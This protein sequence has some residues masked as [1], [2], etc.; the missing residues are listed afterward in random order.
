MNWINLLHFYQ[1]PNQDGRLLR[2]IAK[3]SY[4]Y[5]ISTLKKNPDARCSV[6]I[7][8]SLTE[9]L[10]K[11]KLNSV[12]NG[13]KDLAKN[14]QIEIV[15]TAKYHPILPLIPK[16]E[17]V[18]QIELNDKITRA[19]FGS[20]YNPSG[21][22][23]PELAYSE[24]VAKIIKSRGYKWI[25]LDEVSHSGQLGCLNYGK[26]YIIKNNGLE[27][28]FRNRGVSKSYV[29]EKIL[30]FT[31]YMVK[32]DYVITATD[33]EMYGHHH[34]D[35]ANLYNKALQNPSVKTATM[36]QLLRM[37]SEEEYVTPVPASWESRPH[38]LQKNIPYALWDD[39]KNKIHSQLWKLA[40]FAIKAV[41]ENTESES[42]DWARKHLDV[43]LASCHWWWASERKPDAFTPI[44]W[45]PNI[46]ERGA[47]ELISSIRSLESTSPETKIHAEELFLR[48][49]KDVWKK[50]W[51]INKES[52]R[53][54]KPKRFN[55]ALLT[56]RKENVFEKYSLTPQHIL[57]TTGHYYVTGCV[58]KRG[59]EYILKIRLKDNALEKKLFLKEIAFWKML[60]RL[61]HYPLS[62]P[63][64][65][66]FD[67][68]RKPEYLLYQKID[69][70]GIGNLHYIY[71]IKSSFE[72]VKSIFNGL[73][74]LQKNTDKIRKGLPRINKKTFAENMKFFRSFQTTAL[75]YLPKESLADAEKIIKKN[76]KF[77]NR[78]PLV[79]SHG[80]L[81]PRNIIVSGKKTAL[82]DWSNICLNNEM[83][84]VAFLSLYFLLP[85]KTDSDVYSAFVG[86]NGNDEKKRLFLLNQ[87]II[88]PK[89]IQIQ[90]DSIKYADTI[91]KKIIYD[92]LDS[93]KALIKE[94]NNVLLV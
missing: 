27:V 61:K 40:N 50:H 81:N 82:I 29:P 5:I 85:P 35:Y 62:K 43:G 70:Q 89:F 3:E 80:D 84:D 72:S 15:G 51:N 58:N 78:Q 16:K 24:E 93:L 65:I 60:S 14:G 77:I 52:K 87:L 17:V 9:Q 36:T 83:F 8:G 69:G 45:D 44:T 75:Q 88:I 32:P 49:S 13:L 4:L 92:T 28:V 31:K 11:L 37:Y 25:L 79:I 2:Q 19:Y 57:S 54:K 12:I 66:Y 48:I 63:K 21:F 91:Q 55:A 18:R 38:E 1:P 67:V 71:N 23:A 74:Y 10:V 76:K 6:N 86:P 90:S 26:K 20:V 46:I 47:K 39:P 42:F 22:F 56:E 59:V 30:S 41:S 34:K 53:E 68:S 73:R 64:K 94:I 33:A 7:S